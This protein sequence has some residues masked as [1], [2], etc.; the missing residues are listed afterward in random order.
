LLIGCFSDF[1]SGI[2]AL[3]VSIPRFAQCGGFSFG[4]L[5]VH[6][7]NDHCTEE[8]AQRNRTAW[9]RSTRISATAVARIVNAQR[10]E[11]ANFTGPKIF[12]WFP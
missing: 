2:G 9:P 8:Q 10:I 12:G 3:F 1:F 4:T 11:K 5:L 7:D 6:L